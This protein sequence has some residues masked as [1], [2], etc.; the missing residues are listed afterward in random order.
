MTDL[1]KPAYFHGYLDWR[2]QEEGVLLRRLPERLVG[3]YEDQSEAWGIRANC[4]A[5]VR[6]E[7]ETDAKEICFSVSMTGE[8]RP[9]AG[10]GI[11]IDG[12]VRPSLELTVEQLDQ[13]VIIPLD[14]GRHH[15]TV[16]L[17]H[18]VSFVLKRAWTE[19]ETAAEPVL[20]L[21]KKYYALGDSITQGMTGT[22]PAMNYPSQLARFLGMELFNF[23]VGGIRFLPETLEG[24]EDLP[25]PDLVT[26]ALGTNDWS[27]GQTENMSTF[28]K[29]CAAYLKKIDQLYS[30]IPTYL[31]LPL[32]RREE[33]VSYKRGD[34]Q[35]IRDNITRIAAYYPEMK[36]IDCKPMIP[37]EEQYFDDGL[38]PNNLG[39][40]CYGQALC[41]AI[42]QTQ[43]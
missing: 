16:Y 28:L 22:D 25:K 43:E 9:V 27:M 40:A 13:T 41:Q 37:P 24:M 4:C 20:A 8:A 34:L 18:L 14:G 2:Q 29:A 36:V 5:G 15:V 30:G 12:E 31:L 3:W 26:I 7:V 38:H 6:L 23:G 39:F 42:K 17:P 33:G 19:G 11:V 35:N 10:F 1:C 32:W 21:Q